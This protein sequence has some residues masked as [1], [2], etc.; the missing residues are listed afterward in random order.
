MK[1][2]KVT[3]LVIDHDD[4]GQEAVERSLE[5]SDYT[6]DII[7]P[8]IMEIEQREIGEWGDSH[9]LNIYSQRRGEYEKLFQN[10]KS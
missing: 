4:V 10:D 6:N 9:P 8:M 3:V 2:Y 7:D 1:A 5:K